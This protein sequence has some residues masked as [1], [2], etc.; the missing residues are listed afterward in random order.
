MSTSGQPRSTN[1]IGTLFQPYTQDEFFH[2][3]RDCNYI[4][5]QVELCPDTNREHIQM[6]LQFPHKTRRTTV[7][8]LFGNANPHLEVAKDVCAANTYC[9]KLETRCGWSITR[10]ELTL[11]RQRTDLKSA[12]ALARTHGIRKVHEEMPEVALRYHAGLV[13]HICMMDKGKEYFPCET[14]VLW[15]PTRSG[16]TRQV[17]DG[18]GRVRI[19]PSGMTWYDDCIDREV[20]YVDDFYGNCRT[21]EFLQLTDNYAFPMRVMGGFYPRKYTKVYITSNTPPTEWFKMAPPSVK[22]AIL[23]RLKV[24]FVPGPQ[25][26]SSITPDCGPPYPRFCGLPPVDDTHVSGV[27]P[28]FEG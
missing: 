26:G 28:G 20:I 23:A 12:A 24:N 17:P 8:T 1:W 18:A 27:T 4:A 19:D 11:P 22:E 14:I 6:F 7:S 2:A 9:T 15:G 5:A 13:K 10:G 25:S 21:T 16:K 3:T